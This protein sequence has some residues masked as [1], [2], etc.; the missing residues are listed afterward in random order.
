MFA[1]FF[2]FSS[3]FS[4]QTTG[5]CNNIFAS[6]ALTPKT[7]LLQSHSPSQCSPAGRCEHNNPPSLLAQPQFLSL[8][9][10]WTCSLGELFPVIK[11]SKD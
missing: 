11:Y 1:L 2:L 6:A 5:L 8:P 10:S 7:L 3:F 4:L 9:S